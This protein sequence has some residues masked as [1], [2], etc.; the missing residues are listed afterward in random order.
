[1][2][3]LNYQKWKADKVESGE[4]RQTIR[5]L[6][7]RPFRVGDRLYHYS[8]LRTKNCRKLGESFCVRVGRIRIEKRGIT[9]DGRQLWLSEEVALARADGFATLHDM[10]KWFQS[11]HRLPFN[12]QLVVWEVFESVAEKR[13]KGGAW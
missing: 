6:R 9:L 1:M 12:G 2:P 13:A 3:V 5:G 10:L 7:T 11:T 8:G 4:C